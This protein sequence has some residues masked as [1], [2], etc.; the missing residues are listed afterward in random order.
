MSRNSKNGL[1]R[2]ERSSWSFVEKRCQ[3]QHAQP[4]HRMRLSFEKLEIKTLT[5][6]VRMFELSAASGRANVDFY[7]H[8]GQLQLK[9]SDLGHCAVY[10]KE[11]Q[12]V[13]PITE[14][15]RRAKI[16][17]FGEKHGFRLAY[18]KQGH[19]A[20]FLD[21]SASP[22]QIAERSNAPGLI[23]HFGLPI[24]KKLKPS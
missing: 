21:D 17:E 23:A 9:A 11:L 3:F 24:K 1:E 5:E 20:I 19:C 13:W 18:Y 7:T 15:N 2:H 10:E 22:R 6:L 4:L 14:E 12:R 16:A 8:G